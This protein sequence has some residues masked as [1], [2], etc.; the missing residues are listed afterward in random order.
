[1]EPRKITVLDSATQQKVEIMTDASTF[2]QL[3]A[4]IEAHGISTN[5]KDF[6]EGITKTQPT[7]DDSQLPTNV[8]FR[9]T[10]TNNLVYMMTN[11][12]KKISSGVDRKELYAAVK[13][14][15]LVDVV[16]NKYGRN[17]T[18]VSNDALA[19]V[20]AAHTE[21]L[22]SACVECS[23][24][25]D[26]NDIVFAI[27]SMLVNLNNNIRTKVIECMNS[28]LDTVEEQTPKSIEFSSKDLD[29]MF[30]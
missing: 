3:K 17:Y 29:E 28:I 23:V 16:K 8:N 18:Q 5:G 4:A 14:Y 9:G 10:T 20:V 1:M 19:E 30:A 21:S 15:N 26:Y 13:E 2:G 6:L 25:E 27:A 7:S 24:C 12:N 11:T 22:K